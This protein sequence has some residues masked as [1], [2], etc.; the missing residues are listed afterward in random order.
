[1]PKYLI[2]LDLGGTWM[3]GALA[4]AQ[5]GPGYAVCGHSPILKTLRRPNPL[6]ATRNAAEFATQVADFCR[7]LTGGDSPASVVAA[8]AGEVDAAGKAYLCAGAHLGVMGTAPWVDLLAR[9]FN[10]PIKLINDAEAFLLGAAGKGF[11]PTDRDTG[12]LVIGTG[13]GFTI[14]RKG[15]WWKPA[16]RLLHLGAVEAGEGDYNRLLS[17]VRAGERNVFSGDHAD[18]M[19]RLQYL[20]ALAGT[21][22][23]A[24]HLFH[25]EVILLGGGAIDAARSAGIELAPAMMERLP[26]RLLPGYSCPEIIALED[27]NQTTLEGAMA[28]AAG[29]LA[30]ES[31]R[32]TRDFSSIATETG[33]AGPAIETL[34]PQE[35]V[36]RLA[37]EEAEAS[38]RF[39]TQA[40]VLAQGSEMIAEAIRQGN[41]VIYLG[42]GTSGRVG[43]LDAVEIPCTFGLASDRFLAVIAGG[44]ADAALTIEDQFEED[45]S[46]VADLILLGLR[47]GDVVVG[48]S[49]SGTAFFVRSGLGF[50]K[51][52]GAETILIHEAG[53]AGLEDQLASLSIRLES[54]PEAITGSTR[55]KAGT[56]TKK[57][58][59][60][61]STTSMILL[62]KVR[63]GEM[64]DL[65]C[66]NAKLRERAVRI[67]MKLGDITREDA[68]DRLQKMNYN[69]REALESSQP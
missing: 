58:L 56:A 69:L 59:N 55:M 26:Q 35:I 9:N 3:K 48:I 34:S 60:I 53:M 21:I 33:T 57:A 39:Q 61:L 49:A 46:S 11:V 8:T 25:L 6:G 2:S 41:R 20:D 10:A 47:P 28:L 38:E 4:H 66:C 50:A 65:N 63:G 32:F 68:V 16:R 1:M 12:S 67:L 24:A 51:A 14:A 45:S 54:G 37:R 36:H 7:E 22:A 43:A 27:A 52:V 19:S 40:P 29:D 62:G 42:A 64:I 44:V 13:L 30:A 18:E 17:A 15:R 23:T 5:D 31:A